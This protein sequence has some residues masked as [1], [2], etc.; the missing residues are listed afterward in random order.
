MESI[1]RRNELM[2][3]IQI[4]EFGDPEVMQLVDLP[5]PEPGEGQVRIKVEAIGVNFAD[6]AVRKGVRPVSLPFV[7]GSEAAGVIDKVGPGVEDFKD[8]DRVA[9]TMQMGAYAEF[10]VVSPEKLIQ[11]PEGIDLFDAAGMM[12]HG[13]T[14][15]YL[16]ETTY[17]VRAGDVVLIHAAAGG[18][19]TML[20]QMA[21]RRGGTVIGTT[22]TPAKAEVVKGLGADHVILY[23]E[24]DFA[25][26]VKQIT[27]DQGVHVVYDS[28][29]KSTFEKSLTLLR[30]FGTMVLFGQSSGPVDPI[31][32]NI[33]NQNGSL[34]L[35]YPSL[36]HN[37]G[38]K[39]LF[40]A[41]TKDLVEWV[42][43]G[44]IR[45]QVDRVLQLKA[46]PAA[47]RMLAE[48]QNVGK[49]LLQP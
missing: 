10:A 49:L 48:R 14:G 43:A 33:L 39:E 2:K 34:Y 26:E 15:H 3:A 23:T 13:L 18:V 4:K 17:P 5:L 35:T 45:V 22:S 31:A 6:T 9:Y 46:A 41:R 40:Q 28:V 42:K 24:I 38:T 37:A 36:Y 44:E 12:S 20:V 8:G 25:E 29:G 16:T 11:V 47:H 30:Q 32:P 19:G 27:A 21:K 7:P 1:K